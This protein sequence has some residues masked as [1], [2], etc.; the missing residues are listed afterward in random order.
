M[1]ICKHCNL[2]KDE[3]TEF[4]PGKLYPSSRCIPCERMRARITASTRYSDVVKG[5]KIRS[6]RKERD[7]LP[8]VRDRSRERDK[9]RHERDGEK[10]RKL[11][12]DYF[13][14][15]KL[16]IYSNVN[17]RIRTLAHVKLRKMYHGAILTALKSQSGSKQ[18]RS[19]IE[20]LPYTMEELRKYIEGL[21]D[22]WMH[23]ANHGSYDKKRRT[24]QID[25]I[26][27]QVS[28]PFDSLS[29]PN[30]LKCWALSNLRP[31]ESLANIRKGDR[32]L[33]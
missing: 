16:S 30:F 28:F 25:H 20:F 27:P 23:W 3:I 9:K 32:I 2:Q 11:S 7:A 10:R 19:F 1:R 13:Q 18:N 17:F 8:D 5:P 21:W 33:L 4:Y 24:W 15:N 22:P 14:K 29:H 12:A 26:I 31:L 6:C